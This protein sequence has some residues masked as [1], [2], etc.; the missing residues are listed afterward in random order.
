MFFFLF[1]LSGFG[2][3]LLENV[4]PNPENFV[5]AGIIK[6]QSVQM[7]T[8][9]R[10]EPNRQAQ[11]RELPLSERHSFTFVA[12]GKRQIHSCLHFLKR[13]LAFDANT[14][15]TASLTAPQQGIN[16]RVTSI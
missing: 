2:M 12:N 13:I 14:I 3:T 8:L 11:V 1:Q 7:G 15:I 10:L 16:I 6:A 5:C 4:D 9:L